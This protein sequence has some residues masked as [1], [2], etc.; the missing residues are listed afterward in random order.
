MIDQDDLA[1]IMLRYDGRTFVVFNRTPNINFAVRN[2]RFL[3]YEP[4]PI[5]E[6]ENEAPI[7]QT[8]NFGVEDLGSLARGLRPGN[9]LQ[10][11]TL[12]FV[13]LPGDE[14]PADMCATRT[15]FRQIAEPFW[16]S[17]RPRRAYLEVRLGRVDVLTT[18]PVMIPDTFTETRCL[19]DLPGSP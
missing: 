14:P 12:R 6:D 9:C 8:I 13:S 19:V 5:Y 1:E 15:Y 3:L 4:D 11:W 16:I 10:V 18:C 2:L 7:I 17:E